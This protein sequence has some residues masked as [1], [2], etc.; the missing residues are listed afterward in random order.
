MFSHIF[1]GKYFC[2]EIKNDW[3]DV[4][5]IA[6]FR[7]SAIALRACYFFVYM[8]AYELNVRMSD[9]SPK[10]DIF[11]AF[12]LNKNQMR[13]MPSSFEIPISFDDWTNAGIP[14]QYE[15]NEMKWKDHCRCRCAL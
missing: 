9:W 10:I 12:K 11:A 5:R 7:S 1:T 13:Q 15:T 2:I 3:K 4:N 14:T 8:L 6:M